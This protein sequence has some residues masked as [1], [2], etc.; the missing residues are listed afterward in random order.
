MGREGRWEKRRIK[1]HLK[2]ATIS[3]AMYLP[4]CEPSD[5]EVCISG[6]ARTCGGYLYQ[7]DQRLTPQG[8]SVV[9]LDTNLHQ[10]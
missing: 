6:R 10:R 8:N 7:S 2:T 5:V 1:M 4:E 9:S 3:L